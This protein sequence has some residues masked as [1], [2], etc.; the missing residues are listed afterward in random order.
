MRPEF[1]I[2]LTVFLFVVGTAS[3]QP[4]FSR[5]NRPNVFRSG[6]GE[7]V[8]FLVTSAFWIFGFSLAVWSFSKITWYIN[9]PVIIGSFI[10][11]SLLFHFLPV[12][13]RESAFG[14]LISAVGLILLNSWAWFE[15]VTRTVY[16]L[17]FLTLMLVLLLFFSRIKLRSDKRYRIGDEG[18]FLNSS[19]IQSIPDD[20]LVEKQTLELRDGF[21]YSEAIIDSAQEHLQRLSQFLQPEDEVWIFRHSPGRTGWSYSGLALRRNGA[22]VKAVM[23][24]EMH[25]NYGSKK[26]G[27]IDKSTTPQSDSVN[28]NVPVLTREQVQEQIRLWRK[29]GEARESR[30]SNP[31]REDIEYLSELEEIL[32][33]E[34]LEAQ[35]QHRGFNWH[36]SPDVVVHSTDPQHLG[37]IYV[38]KDQELNP[39]LHQQLLASRVQTLLDLSS[40]P[41]ALCK[42]IEREYLAPVGIEADSDD[43]FNA[44]RLWVELLT[45]AGV[46]GVEGA[47]LAEKL[48][49]IENEEAHA[50][51][52]SE[53][54]NPEDALFSWVSA[55]TASLR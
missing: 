55:A 32:K 45:D 37:A 33:Q 35:V 39:V 21:P 5:L 8:F 36:K 14:P 43:P 50:L 16:I 2:A 25:I 53:M 13:L 15:Q 54:E 34:D 23:T 11:S 26:A 6:L 48:M 22:I 24:S 17:L 19:R 42:V 27:A 46:F 12:I 1:V 20:W 4:M 3:A 18:I 51:L 30:L 29:D 44:A 9:V 10:A 49:P 31:S 7:F 28:D 41:K 38:K 47:V 40:D 52:D